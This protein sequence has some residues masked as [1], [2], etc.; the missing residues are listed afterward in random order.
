MKYMK[1][2]TP[3]TTWALR[4][5]TSV[6]IRRREKAQWGD[7]GADDRFSQIRSHAESA[8]QFLQ[9]GYE[10]AL[11]TILGNFTLRWWWDGKRFVTFDLSAQLES[12]FQNQFAKIQIF[13]LE[14]PQMKRKRVK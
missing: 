2:N 9:A 13:V 11:I 12:C 6:G 1:G 10:G 8:I 5:S 7:Y 4:S 14:Q 3:S